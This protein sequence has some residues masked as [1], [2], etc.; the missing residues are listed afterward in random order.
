MFIDKKLFFG[1]TIHACLGINIIS[2]HL[3][4]I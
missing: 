1:Q 4:N 2:D 3:L